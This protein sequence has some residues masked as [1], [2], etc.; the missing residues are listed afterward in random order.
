MDI[1]GYDTG[2]IPCR[3]AFTADFAVPTGMPIQHLVNAIENE[4]PC[5]DVRPGMRHKYT[6]LR[7]DPATS[8]HQVGGRY[9]FD[10]WDNAVDYVRFTSEL[11]FEPGVKFWDRP[12]FLNIDKHL[13]HVA[14]AHDF[15]PMASTHYVNRLERFS[16]T[17][18][19]P[20][21]RLADAW[22]AVCEA[23]EAHGLA[24]TW[25]LFQSDD[26]QI[27]IVT[28]AARVAAA[29]DA[30]AASRSLAA[31]DHAA[32]LSA[33]L[34]RE[35]ALRKLFDRTSLNLSLWLPQS[36]RAGGAPS[37]FPTFPVHPLPE[38]G[39]A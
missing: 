24:S 25:L 5:M 22:P 16:Y 35:L 19:S 11:E 37:A 17:G 36:R 23:A 4:R 39:A 26:R 21:D 13:W 33:H 8:A 1:L 15:T 32:S 12:F 10:S 27:G 18:G 31:L 28:V 20:A 9:L 2:P 14:G 34:P 30:D 3:A 29:D 6:P 38:V 7:F